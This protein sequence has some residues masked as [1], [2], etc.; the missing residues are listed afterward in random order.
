MILNIY[1]SN[2]IVHKFMQQSFLSIKEKEVPDKII[3]GYFN[4]ILS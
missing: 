2:I 4:S 1:A 3:M